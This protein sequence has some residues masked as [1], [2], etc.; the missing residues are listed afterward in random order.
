MPPFFG[1]S[2]K[3]LPRADG[4][5]QSCHVGA[6]VDGDFVVC[7]TAGTRQ[8]SNLCRVPGL[9][10]QQR[11]KTLPRAEHWHSTKFKALPSA[12][13]RH[14]AKFQTLPSA[15]PLA[16]GKVWIFAECQCYSTRQ[17]FFPACPIWSLYR[18]FWLM[19]SAKWPIFFWYC[20]LYFSIQ[21]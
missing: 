5:R 1:H 15:D 21:I 8:S 3:M 9:G 4:T 6:T 18:V 11:F 10:T 19:H 7:L 16:L 2:A 14:S 20:F 13:P 17:S 12:I